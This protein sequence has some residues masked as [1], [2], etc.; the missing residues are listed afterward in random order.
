MDIAGYKATLARYH[1]LSRDEEHA[2]LM[3]A[4]AGDGRARGK[5]VLSNLRFALMEASRFARYSSRSDPEDLLQEALLALTMA[6]DKWEPEHGTRLLT[7]A[8]WWIKAKLHRRVQ[9]DFSLVNCLTTQRA[10]SNLGLKGKVNRLTAKGLTVDEAL[11]EIS[12]TSKW[13]LNSLRDA[14]RALSHEV[15][16]LDAPIGEDGPSRIDLLPGDDDALGDIISR[17]SGAEVRQAVCDCLESPRERALASRR[18][19]SDD[20]A[21]LAEIGRGFGVSRERVRQIETSVLR[22]VRKKLIRKRR[23]QRGVAA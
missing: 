22:L 10:R 3:R 21:T 11:R 14:Y 4:K 6:A 23:K 1:P 13:S 16:S 18:L 12:V 5:L 8:V 19:L 7:M 20:P 2:L 17:E 15:V 9:G